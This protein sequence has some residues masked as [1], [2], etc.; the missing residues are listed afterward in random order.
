MTP[1]VFHKQAPEQVLEIKTIDNTREDS[2]EPP[3]GIH[4]GSDKFSPL[5]MLS[6][7][8]PAPDVRIDRSWITSK[9][10]ENDSKSFGNAQRRVDG[11]HSLFPRRGNEKNA[12]ETSGEAAKSCIANAGEAIGRLGRKKTSIPKLPDL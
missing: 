1:C 8:A 3:F 4:L 7:A 9:H 2:S 10:R 11:H 6:R 5:S 12:L